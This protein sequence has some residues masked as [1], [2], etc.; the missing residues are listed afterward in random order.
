MTSVV[1][2]RSR[3]AIQQSVAIIEPRSNATAHDCLSHLVGQPTVHV[4]EGAGVIVTRTRYIGGVAVESEVRRMV[5]PSDLT[6]SETANRLP[7]TLIIWMLAA[8]QSWCDVPRITTSD[9][10]A[11][12]CSPFHKNHSRTADEQSARMLRLSLIHI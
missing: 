2:G 11:L 12:S 10:S 3:S 6:R 5:T 4:T 1:D 9:L 7:A 8:A